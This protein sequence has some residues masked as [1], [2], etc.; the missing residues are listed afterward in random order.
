MRCLSVYH[1]ILWI[2]CSACKTLQ[3]E[4]SRVQKSTTISHRCS[5]TFTGFRF[6]IVSNTRYLYTPTKRYTDLDQPTLVNLLSRI[7]RQ[8]LYDRKTRCFWTF[9]GLERSHTEIGDLTLQ[10]PVLWN[11]LPSELRRAKSLNIFKQNLKTHLFKCAF[12]VWL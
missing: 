10:A 4:W 5:L 12:N 1:A 11:A 2:N 6:R 9:L 3:R 7:V 8:E